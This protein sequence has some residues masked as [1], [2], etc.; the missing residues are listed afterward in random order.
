MLAKGD[1][2]A[3]GASTDIGELALGQNMLVAFSAGI[4][5]WQMS[6][7]LT[8]FENDVSVLVASYSVW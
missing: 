8:H 7:S 3:D 6:R 4:G 2:I 1:V 5:L